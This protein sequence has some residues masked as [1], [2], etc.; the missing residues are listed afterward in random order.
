MKIASLPPEVYVVLPLAI[1]GE[2]FCRW[3]HCRGDLQAAFAPWTVVA[4][5]YP[6][7]DERV[8]LTLAQKIVRESYREQKTPDERRQ[9]QAV[10]LVYTTLVDTE[11]AMRRDHPGIILTVEQRIAAAEIAA[12][13]LRFKMP[14]IGCIHIDAGVDRY[15]AKI[16]A[17]AKP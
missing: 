15:I 12:K 16:K 2:A 4:S 14:E 10:D 5:K 13:D 7:L 6:D 17:E 8:S 11:Q 3:W 1:F 9:E